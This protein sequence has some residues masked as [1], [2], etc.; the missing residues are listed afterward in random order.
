[1]V[2]MMRKQAEN[3]LVSICGV[4]VPIWRGLE[5]DP[6]TV[7]RRKPC[8]SCTYGPSGLLF[9]ERREEDERALLCATVVPGKRPL[10]ARMAQRYRQ[11]SV[12]HLEASQTSC[13]QLTKICEVWPCVQRC[14]K[15]RS[16]RQL[17]EKNSTVSWEIPQLINVSFPIMVDHTSLEKHEHESVSADIKAASLVTTPKQDTYC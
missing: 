7:Q 12:R 5:T 10:V 2:Q 11:T 17:A 15:G 13:S 9:S 8:T 1:M 4:I 6:S 14:I 16:V 3:T